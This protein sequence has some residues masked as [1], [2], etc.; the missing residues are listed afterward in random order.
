M[1][2]FVLILGFV[3][4]LLGAGFFLAP[5]LVDLGANRTGPY[6]AS[7]ASDRARALLK[8]L[9]TVD[10]HDDALL[11][12]R[13]LNERGSHGHVDIPRMIEGNL[14]LQA[15][16]VVTKTPK[17]LKLRGNEDDWDHLNLLGP[18]AGWPESARHSL[19]G[20]ALYQSK[21]LHGFAER[22]QGTFEIITSR[23]ELAAYLEKRKTNP[24]LAAGFLGF[25]GAQC[26]EGKLEN[27]DV[28]YDA[29]FRMGAPTHFTDTEMG[30]SAHGVS[31]GG[32]TPLGKAWVKKMEEKK[33]LIDVSHASKRTIDDVLAI[34]TRPVM[35]SHTGVKGTC[36]TDRNL[37][38]DQLVAIAKTGGV[39]GI[40][41]FK[42]AIC[43]E[44][45][46]AIARA[47]AY[48]VKLVG[49][50][51]V[52]LGSDWDGA[53][54]TPFDAT[55]LPVLIDAL[56]AEGLTDEQIKLVMGEN[57]LRLLSEALP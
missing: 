14:W 24:S 20:R 56:L 31:L 45:P 50:E 16:T 36:D 57:A 25:E 46:L 15:F 41:Y 35:V 7:Q 1:R 33:M 38:D 21:K 5:T 8:T 55:G 11:W 32:L 29:G 19:L 13:D 51:H 40:G 43:G 6:K 42:T 49:A 26:L 39:I 37:P 44:S 3:A 52:A 48:T 27:L 54:K 34:A 22:S 53:V 30:G 47:I 2:K 9:R 23:A 17:Y 12:G 28:L 10:L 4:I 18:A